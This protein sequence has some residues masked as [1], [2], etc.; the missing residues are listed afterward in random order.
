M[1]VM[2]GYKMI[3]LQI[4]KLGLILLALLGI[5]FI[6]ISIDLFHDLV[7]GAIKDRKKKKTD[8]SKRRN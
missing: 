8:I 2:G 7:I 6:L 4:S 5:V 3:Y 1:N